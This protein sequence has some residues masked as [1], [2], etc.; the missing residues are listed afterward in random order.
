[1]AADIVV[2]DFENLAPELPE[3]SNDFPTG[4]PRLTQRCKGI[5]CTIVNGQVLVDNGAHTG[6]LPGQVLRNSLAR[7]LRS[8]Q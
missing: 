3:V 6:A 1:M 2:F 5:D 4:A 8:L 7:R